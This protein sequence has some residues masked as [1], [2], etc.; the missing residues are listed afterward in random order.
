MASIQKQMLGTEAVRA[1]RHKGFKGLICGLSANAMDD[2]FLDAGADAF[3]FKPFPC[4]VSSL[5]K[6][7]CR[8]IH[9]GDAN[10]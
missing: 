8:I 5:T 3:M 10:V 4:E 1:L 2:A 6:E 7:L 9:P